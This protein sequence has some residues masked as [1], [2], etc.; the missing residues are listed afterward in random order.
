M[1]FY[2]IWEGFIKPFTKFK[3]PVSSL[4]KFDQFNSLSNTIAISSTVSWS[5]FAIRAH[6]PNAQ[7]ILIEFNE[8]LFILSKASIEASTLKQRFREEF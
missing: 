1:K 2:R 5:S 6:S 7:C 8:S 3:T 4:S